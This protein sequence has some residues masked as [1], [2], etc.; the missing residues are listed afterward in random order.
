MS[1][2][3]FL[4]ADI[5]IAAAAPSL[6]RLVDEKHPRVFQSPAASD[7]HNP[8]VLNDLCNLAR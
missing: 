6:F 2:I 4:D 3:I 5:L 8:S 1:A 7:L